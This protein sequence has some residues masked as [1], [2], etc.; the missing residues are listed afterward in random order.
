MKTA[1]FYPT[2]AGLQLIAGATSN[3]DA[4]IK[5][6][7]EKEKQEHFFSTPKRF[8]SYLKEN[9]YTSAVKVPKLSEV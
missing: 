7:T 4:I 9:G 6:H 8:Q 2:L 5:A 1:Y 3:K